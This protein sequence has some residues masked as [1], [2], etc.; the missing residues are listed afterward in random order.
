MYR[1]TD[2]IAV[3]ARMAAILAT[4]RVASAPIPVYHTPERVASTLAVRWR[5]LH[6]ASAHRGRS[7]RVPG[8]HGRVR[9]HDHVAPL[10]RIRG[11]RTGRHRQRPAVLGTADT[12]RR[13]HVHRRRF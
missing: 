8:A 4:R 6:A 12:S 9:I 3:S 2:A 1:A 7:A 11:V 13:D 10:L 5:L